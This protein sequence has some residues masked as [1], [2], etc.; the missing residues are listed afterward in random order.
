[1]TACCALGVK[2]HDPPYSNELA[3]TLKAWPPHNTHQTCSIRDLWGQRST[4]EDINTFPL[5][6]SF[7]LAKECS[8]LAKL[9]LFIAIASFC[10][11]FKKVV[12]LV[13]ETRLKASGDASTQAIY[14]LHD[15]SVIS[16]SAV[17][18]LSIPSR[19]TICPSRFHFTKLFSFSNAHDFIKKKSTKRL[20]LLRAICFNWY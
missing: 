7:S 18:P 20:P 6:T 4:F 19:M 11:S 10:F 13:V 3:S 2:Q 8:Q 12:E 17:N 14:I 5:G 1:M 9:I 15:R 16:C